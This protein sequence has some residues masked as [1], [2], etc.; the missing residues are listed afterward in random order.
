[1]KAGSGPWW[2]LTV[3]VCAALPSMARD[4]T[5]WVV[6][7]GVTHLP[8][9]QAAVD[10][11]AQGDTVVVS[12]GTYSGPGNRDV[13]VQGKAITIQGSLPD[14]PTVVEQTVI[15]CAG[16]L[17]EPHRAFYIVDCN[18][19]VLSG[20]TITHGLSS[21]GGA[22]YCRSSML[23]VADCRII[24]NGALPGGAEDTNG[25]PGGGLYGENSIV[26]VVGCLISGNTAGTGAPS[27][28]GPAGAGGNG[29]GISCVRSDL[30]VAWSTISGNAA[31]GGG[32]SGQGAAGNGGDGG[33]LCGNAVQI[34][35]STVSLNAAGTGGQGAQ[36]GRGGRGGG[37]CANAVSMDLCILAGNRAGDEGK[38]VADG[39]NVQA[40]A[41]AM[42][43]ASTAA[44]YWRSPAVSS[45][46][47]GPV[48]G[49]SPA[50]PEGWTTA[51]A[52]ASG[53]PAGA[54][55]LCTITE[56]AVCRLQETP[57]RK[58][59]PPPVAAAEYS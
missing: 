41:A 33:G 26:Q 47:T 50:P 2:P 46:A 57:T 3:L 15:D 52:A 45:R 55:R 18:G 28:D 38:A 42:A 13:V 9:I 53:V 40:P 27:K 10:V 16:S 11:A 21:A 5:T 23:E 12:P 32:D 37:I 30:S 58:S 17:K 51:M 14:D 34:V 44:C 36:T 8:T 31:G 6:G 22:V 43:A 19:V 4:A 7:S 54:V 1:M 48:E 49:M 24:D 35:N 25:G 59:S 20:L 56:N 29:G 39:N